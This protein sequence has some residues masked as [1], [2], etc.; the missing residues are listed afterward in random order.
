MIWSLT[1]D[2]MNLPLISN[3]SILI[4]VGSLTI[5]LMDVVPLNGLG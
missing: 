5:I 2:S 1:K 4:F 3:I